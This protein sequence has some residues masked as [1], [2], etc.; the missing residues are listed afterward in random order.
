MYEE[1]AAGTSYLD[2]CK[3]TLEASCLW[4]WWWQRYINLL[5]GWAIALHI[6]TKWFSTCDAAIYLHQPTNTGQR[7]EPGNLLYQYTKIEY[8]PLIP[9]GSRM[10][11]RI[12]CKICTLSRLL[13]LCCYLMPIPML[14]L[15]MPQSLT[16]CSVT[17][18]F[19]ISTYGHTCI[20]YPKKWRSM[21]LSCCQRLN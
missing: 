20:F 10:I 9:G 17:T 2:G 7:T 8:S 11:R 5:L 14:I 1:L 12:F 19:L 4:V 18:Y 21:H 6:S 16:L 15:D 3:L 13:Y